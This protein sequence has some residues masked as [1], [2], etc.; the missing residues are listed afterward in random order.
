MSLWGGGEKV[1]S[2][3]T[4]GVLEVLRS[5]ILQDVGVVILEPKKEEEIEMKLLM[6]MVGGL[7]EERVW[8]KEG[9][10]RRWE[11]RASNAIT[12]EP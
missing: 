8:P 1:T 7:R 12:S 6:V 3:G 9:G 4:K 10:G 2:C 5:G 11:A